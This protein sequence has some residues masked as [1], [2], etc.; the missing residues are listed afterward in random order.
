[1]TYSREYYLAHKPQIRKSQNK[2]NKKK[3]AQNPEPFKRKMKNYQQKLKD[4]RIERMDKII[5]EW[6]TMEEHVICPLCKEYVE[7]CDQCRSPLTVDDDIYCID[8]GSA[9]V[10]EAC[11]DDYL[12]DQHELDFTQLVE[13]EE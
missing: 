9:H 10:C 13:E 8:N 7:K 11:V 3:Y 2:Y 6:I 4:T 1:M 12:R 5:E